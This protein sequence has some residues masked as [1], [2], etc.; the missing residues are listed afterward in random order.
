MLIRGRLPGNVSYSIEAEQAEGCSQP[1][2]AVGSLGDRTDCAFAESLANLPRRVRVLADVER[3]IDREGAEAACQKNARQRSRQHDR[4]PHSSP[5][6]T[7][8]GNILSHLWNAFDHQPRNPYQSPMDNLSSSGALFSAA[9]SRR[10]CASVVSL[11]RLPCC[12]QRGALRPIDKRLP[13]RSCNGRFQSS[14]R[15]RQDCNPQLGH[16]YPI[17]DGDQCGGR[18]L[19][20]ESSA[21]TL[22]H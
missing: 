14:H 18:V 5:H 16:K 10:K 4:M 22:S 11:A 17:S 15:R 3:R 21:R 19:D 13:L 9:V 20:D 7:P 12:I 2:I 1:E 8:V 6:R